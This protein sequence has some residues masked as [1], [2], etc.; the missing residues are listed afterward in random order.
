MRHSQEKILRLCQFIIRKQRCEGRGGGAVHRLPF[1][2][3][4]PRFQ[5]LAVDE[6]VRALSYLQTSIAAIVNHDDQ[7][8]S[9]E[10][11]RLA[12]IVFTASSQ[13]HTSTTGTDGSGLPLHVCRHCH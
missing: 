1:P 10:F 13:P 6:P 12:S 11:R 3:C 5:E 2:S 9:E 7:E 8:E 4:L